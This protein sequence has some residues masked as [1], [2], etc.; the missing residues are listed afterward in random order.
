MPT[1]TLHG[2][3]RQEQREEA[4]ANFRSGKHPILIATNIAARGL[5]IPNVHQVINFEMPGDIGE[6]VHRIGR[7]GRCGNHG[8][9]ISFYESTRDKRIAA[10]ILQIL[11]GS[12]QQVPN[13]LIEEVEGK[14][15]E[16]Q[17]E[18]AVVL[19]NSDSIKSMVNKKTNVCDNDSDSDW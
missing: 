12:G 9:A 5:Y 19:N 15:F 6:Y 11:R 14:K 13:W 17:E 8:R 2:D 16:R 7:T 1:T 4:L 10:D 18:E 3:R